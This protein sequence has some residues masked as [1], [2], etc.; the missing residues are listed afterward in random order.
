MNK[1]NKLQ[2]GFCSKYA[3]I[4]T[5]FLLSEQISEAR[6]NKQIIYTAMVDASK[7]FD[8][9]WHDGMLFNLYQLGIWLLYQD[10]YNNMTSHIKW[11]KYLAES[12][13]EKQGV[14]QGG[15]P[16]LNYLKPELLRNIDTCTTHLGYR[17][18]IVGVATHACADDII[19]LSSSAINLQAMLDIAADDA[20]Q[21]RYQYSATKTTAIY[22]HEH[23]ETCNYLG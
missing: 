6:D 22:G 12:F 14:R 3:S 18:G 15:I 1:L 9:V 13:A 2:R 20:S 16:S 19:L 11:N 17:I 8:V 5:A 10:M 4:N 21:E 7:A 23:Q